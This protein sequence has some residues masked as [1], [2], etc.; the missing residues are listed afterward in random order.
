MDRFGDAVSILLGVLPGMAQEQDLP[1]DLSHGDGH[2]HVSFPSTGNARTLV[3]QVVKAVHF[4]R[5]LQSA[6]PIVISFLARAV[7][8]AL[9]TRHPR[10]DLGLMKRFAFR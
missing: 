3:C 9:W 1:G 7:I 4:R 5:L 10:S 8:V 6:F 2:D